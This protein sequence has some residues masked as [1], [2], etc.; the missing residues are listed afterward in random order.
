MEKRVVSFISNQHLFRLW[1]DGVGKVV[2]ECIK[3]DPDEEVKIPEGIE[4]HKDAIVTP[5]GITIRKMRKLLR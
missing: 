4:I 3:V 1:E 2:L 5:G